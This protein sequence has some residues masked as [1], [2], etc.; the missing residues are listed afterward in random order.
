MTRGVLVSPPVPGKAPA[1][2]AASGPRAS[3][4]VLTVVALALTLS[5]P[6]HARRDGLPDGVISEVKIEGNVTITPEQIRAKLLSRPGH[7]LDRRMIDADLKSLLATKWFSE[8]TPYFESPTP[9]GKGFIL[10]FAS[11]RCPS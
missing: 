4:L 3:G 7:P 10:I 5:G 9:S 6:A 11:R 2:R 1:D 8:V